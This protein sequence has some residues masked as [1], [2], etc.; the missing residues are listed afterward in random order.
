M[1]DAS[2][3]DGDTPPPTFGDSWVSLALMVGFIILA[4]TYL[5]EPFKIPTG[6]MEP[7]LIGHEDFGD[8]ILTN[9]MA[10]IGSTEALLIAGAFLVLILQGLIWSV[11]YAR[12]GFAKDSKPFA[13]VMVLIALRFLR[14]FRFEF[15]QPWFD[16]VGLAL[17]GI[18]ALHTLYWYV[19]NFTALKNY[20]SNVR[21]ALFF[22][23]SGL[24]TG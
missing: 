15:Y 1:S 14:A 6:S 13:V 17:F 24:R 9:K 16:T 19:R 3:P 5:L 11:D 21:W 23:D 10:Y 2:K 22:S 18:V 12:G 20:W 7:T 4:R 8:R